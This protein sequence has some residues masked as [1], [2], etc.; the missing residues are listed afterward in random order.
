MGKLIA[1]VS[2]VVLLV[3]GVA[4]ANLLTN[5]GFETGNLNGWSVDWNAGNQHSSALN[6]QSGSFAAR[7]EFDGGMYQ[8][9]N[10]VVGGTQ[11]QLTGYSYVP[12]GGALSDWGSYIGLKFFNS[13]DQELVN[14]QV[15]TQNLTRGVYNLADTGL[16]LAPAAATYAHVRFGTWANLGTTPA[17]PTDFDTFD[18]EG[19]VVPE[20]T[21]L[22]LLGSGLI[23]LAGLTKKRKA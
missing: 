1:V 10:G 7:N 16:V 5:P 8:L 6:P 3:P 22:L 15:D 2:L 11:Y 4:N 23:G 9:I 21:S 17:K 14:Y 20:P 19:Q 12:T 18:L 13:S